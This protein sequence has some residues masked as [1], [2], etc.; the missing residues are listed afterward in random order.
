MATRDRYDMDMLRAIQ[1][2]VKELEALNRNMYDLSNRC[3]YI[4]TRFEDFGRAAREVHTNELADELYIPT[5][6]KAG[7]IN[8][9]EGL[10]TKKEGVDYV[11]YARD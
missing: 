8:G 4:A 1:K 5:T 2:I 11:D 6:C 7:Y 10:E 9:T 3:S